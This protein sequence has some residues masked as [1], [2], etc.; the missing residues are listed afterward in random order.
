MPVHFLCFNAKTVLN[1]KIKWVVQLCKDKNV[2]AIIMAVLV[3]TRLNIIVVI[4]R[5]IMYT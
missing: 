3:L 5:Y 4:G 1:D 2:R